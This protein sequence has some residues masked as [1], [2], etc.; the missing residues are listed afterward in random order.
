MRLPRS[1][2]PLL[3]ALGILSG[4]DDPLDPTARLDPVPNEEAPGVLD[5]DSIPLPVF[6]LF[7]ATHSIG[8]Q[9]LGTLGSGEI[10]VAQSLNNR[11]HVVGSSTDDAGNLRAFFW[12]P[13]SGLIDL[14]TTGG[15]EAKAHDINEADVVVGSSRDANGN[16]EAFR[17][18]ENTGIVGLGQ[19]GGL[20]SRAFAIN[21]RLMVVGQYTP[22]FDPLDLSSYRGVQSFGWTPSIGFVELPTLGSPFVGMA[23]DI[24]NAAQV[25]GVSAE[26]AD[27][28]APLLAYIWSPG[29]GIRS[30]GAMG[31]EFSEHAAFKINQ[32][33]EV[34]GGAFNEVTQ[35]WH[36]FIWS[37]SDGFTDLKTLGFEPSASGIAIDINFFGHLAVLILEADGTRTPAV[38]VREV[39]VVELP[40]LG[41]QDGEIWAIND[42]GMIVGWTEG[43]AGQMRPALWSVNLAPQERIE[44]VI[45][46]INGIISESADPDLIKDLE[47]AV[48]KAQQAAEALE[49]DNLPKAIDKLKKAVKKLEEAIETALDPQTGATLTEALVQAARE[50]AL[51]TLDNA[52]AFGGDLEDI[53][54]AEVH[55]EDGDAF[56]AAGENEDA[57]DQYKK[58]ASDALKALDFSIKDRLR[59]VLHYID[60]YMMATATSH[61]A[62]DKLDDIATSISAALPLLH[63]DDYGAVMDTV[64]IAVADL[65]Q[66]VADGVFDEESDCETLFDKLVDTAWHLADEAIK[67]AKDRDGDPATIEAAE[68][69]QLD[70]YDLHWS[71]QY[72]EAVAKYKQ[73]LAMALG[74]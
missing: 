19:F 22:A 4:C 17:W 21:D 47:D 31:P 38:W 7:S 60:D 15:L 32:W 8:V 49:D 72:A 62:Y 2:A 44:D 59:D 64:E 58:A 56:R 18:T 34:A 23:Y 41:G 5:A 36:P 74:A 27:P 11:G 37:E 61:A 30:L 55:M 35:T 46:V 1:I 57:V 54:K 53:A 52:K 69:L 28:D 25:V 63:D 70:A 9:D 3:F 10:H 16:Y 26:S 66:A 42:F 14:G 40:T 51:A 65:N 20:E 24:N 33:G 13:A 6:A 71:M 48:E 39:G 68:Q 29:S 43:A 73:A 45:D 50:I 12:S 67:D